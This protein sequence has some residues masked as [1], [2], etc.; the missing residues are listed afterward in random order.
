MVMNVF[1]VVMIVFSMRV[2][3]IWFTLH[4]TII[5]LF[6]ERNMVP[7]FRLGMVI[8]RFGMVMNRF[9]MVMN[10]FRPTMSKSMV[11]MSGFVVLM[12]GFRFVMNNFLIKFLVNWFRFMMVMRSSCDSRYLCHDREVNDNFMTDK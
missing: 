1:R 7:V 4:W 9:R 10:R 2:N 11:F 5:Q 8:N 6:V 12:N 3:R